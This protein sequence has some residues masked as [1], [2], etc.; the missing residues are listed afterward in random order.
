MSL[1]PQ[2]AHAHGEPR[3]LERADLLGRA[4]LPVVTGRHEHE[5]D[6]TVAGAVRRA[7]IEWSVRD[8]ERLTARVSIHR[9]RE[10]NA[11]HRIDEAKDRRFAPEILRERHHGARD[12]I[13]TRGH[14]VP[15]GHVG[16]TE[17]VDALLGI[18][19]EN[20]P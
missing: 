20:E 6:R 8:L 17:A 11:D 5:L 15:Y 2:F 10:L 12:A 4:H 14:P 18:A 19:H 3:G 9:L 1:R 13:K 7:W 16:A